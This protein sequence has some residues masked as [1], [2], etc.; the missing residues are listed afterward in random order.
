MRRSTPAAPLLESLQPDRRA[1]AEGG[2]PRAQ[3]QDRSDLV[4]ESESGRL[5]AEA[6]GDGKP[7]SLRRALRLPG[8]APG[9]GGLSPCG[10][11][12]D[13]FAPARAG[14][15]RGDSSARL[16]GVTTREND[17]PTS[18]AYPCNRSRCALTVIERTA[19]PASTRRHSGVAIAASA[20]RSA[21]YGDSRNPMRP[22][23]GTS[24]C[25]R[26]RPLASL[27][28]RKSLAGRNASS[29]SFPSSVRRTSMLT[30]IGP[31]AIA[32]TAMGSSSRE[33][34]V[35]RCCSRYP[36]RRSCSNTR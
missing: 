28:S 27:A 36:A 14:R 12:I 7:V 11:T 20:P 17:T 13:A 24:R 31:D 9:E 8:A 5:E 30:Q 29:S 32:G 19:H 25:R 18:S 23:P 2:R 33:C 3:L 35:R 22:T 10:F 16:V 26:R 1:A 34:T 6:P 4:D 21:R 15:A